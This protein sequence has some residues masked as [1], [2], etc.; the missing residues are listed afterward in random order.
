VGALLVKLREKTLSELEKELV[1]VWGLVCAQAH[2]NNSVF[3][4]DC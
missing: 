1:T 2:Q 4:R 3:F